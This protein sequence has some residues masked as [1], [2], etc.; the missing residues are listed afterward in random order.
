MIAHHASVYL[1]LLPGTDCGQVGPSPRPFCSFSKP[2]FQPSSFSFLFNGW[3]GIKKLSGTLK[4][5][6]QKRG[7]SV[8]ESCPC[9]LPQTTCSFTQK[10]PK[11][12]K[13]KNTLNGTLLAVYSEWNKRVSVSSWE[14]SSRTLSLSEFGQMLK[15]KSN[16]LTVQCIPVCDI[17]MH[18]LEL[19]W[20]LLSSSAKIKVKPSVENP[21]DGQSVFVL[22]C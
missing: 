4:L 7:E 10:T 18:M 3:T 15:S 16:F 14:R 20:H 21:A 13:K 17:K 8:Q 1:V 5:C 9:L 2:V 11:K 12:N 6:W 19:W 22:Q